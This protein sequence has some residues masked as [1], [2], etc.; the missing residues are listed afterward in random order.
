MP[1]HEVFDDCVQIM[2]KTMDC[3]AIKQR[4]AFF[5]QSD[6]FQAAFDC[7]KK[8]QPVGVVARLNIGGTAQFA[9]GAGQLSVCKR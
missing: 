9:P 7:I 8:Q 2:T 3:I 5:F 4:F 1:R 6:C